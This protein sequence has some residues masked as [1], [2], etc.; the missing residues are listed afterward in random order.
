MITDAM[1]EAAARAMRVGEGSF[2]PMSYWEDVARAALEAAERAAWRP[3]EEAPKDGTRILV[4]HN[5]AV[6]LVSWWDAWYGD[7]SEPGWMMAYCDEESGGYVPATHFR[8][9]PTP[10]G[11]GK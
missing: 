8:P 1:V 2:L 3:I 7:E 6:F 5:G 10:P 9:L 11:A 4:P